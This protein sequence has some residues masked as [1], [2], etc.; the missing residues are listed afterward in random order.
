MNEATERYA[1][2]SWRA[3]CAVA[4][5]RCATQTPTSLEPTSTSRPKCGDP[6]TTF[7][8]KGGWKVTRYLS[9]MVRRIAMARKI[10]VIRRR[11][12]GS[13]GPLIHFARWAPRGVASRRVA[14]RT[15]KV[16]RAGSGRAR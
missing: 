2:Q 12:A 14:P 13:L 4:R 8:G 10:F 7:G 3:A 9:A 5:G 11:R 16:A 1:E 15:S 6:S